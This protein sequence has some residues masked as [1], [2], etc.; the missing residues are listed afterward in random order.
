MPPI[1]RPDPG[2][3]PMSPEAAAELRRVKQVRHD[4]QALQDRT[5]QRTYPE[6]GNVLAFYWLQTVRESYTP[7]HWSILK[8]E[9]DRIA[10]QS[11][12]L[13]MLSN[14]I[15]VSGPKH[16]QAKPE[17][18]GDRIQPFT[19]RE[20]EPPVSTSEAFLERLLNDWLPERILERY[21]VY[22]AADWTAENAYEETATC[23]EEILTRWTKVPNVR[24]IQ[25]LDRLQGR[26]P[27]LPEDVLLGRRKRQASLESLVR[28]PLRDAGVVDPKLR[29]IL[30]DVIL[31]LLGT[32]AP[33]PTAEP[34]YAR[35]IPTPLVSHVPPEIADQVASFPLPAAYTATNSLTIPLQAWPG[36]SS[37]RS[38]LV[39]PDGRLW[40][41]RSVGQ[42]AGA[43]P[44]IEYAAIGRVDMLRQPDGPYL[45]AP[46][47]L[48]PEEVNP[49]LNQSLE[50][51]FYNHRWHMKLI[52]GSG[53]EAYVLYRAVA[54]P[55]GLQQVQPREPKK[56]AESPSLK[57]LLRAS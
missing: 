41:A 42:E 5:R 57:S 48:W 50:F 15:R 11:P 51:E 1:L 29:E 39:T 26:P 9:V 16:T 20:Y 56:A 31:Y 10:Q 47:G 45:K 21:G 28:V 43:Q 35:L 52:E 2:A 7:A 30:D 24:T 18:K 4:I 34:G 55:P 46:L 22:D 17:K 14:W 3:K 44:W 12:V 8:A 54:V 36:S 25:A 53:T 38:T 6:T 13:Q 40:Q 33:A 23:L 49:Q 32:T 27:S 19:S 37:I